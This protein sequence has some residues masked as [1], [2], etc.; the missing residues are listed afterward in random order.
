MNRPDTFIEVPEITG[1]D[2]IPV[3]S[4]ADALRR[5]DNPV[6]L[7]TPAILFTHG[8]FDR[9][10]VMEFDARFPAES[11]DMRPFCIDL[12]KDE[13]FFFEGLGIMPP[14][15]LTKPVNWDKRLYAIDQRRAEECISFLSGI[16]YSNQKTGVFGSG[17]VY[18]LDITDPTSKKND[19]LLVAIIGVISNK[20]VLFLEPRPTDRPVLRRY[21]TMNGQLPPI[22]RTQT[23]FTNFTGE[24]PLKMRDE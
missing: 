21:K 8:G 19:R 20:S 15:G 13:E 22:L 9:D 24:D 17:F 14:P 18:G 23:I 10:P 11:R 12:K 5:R 1:A 16:A 2:A 6:T 4:C 3:L 7:F